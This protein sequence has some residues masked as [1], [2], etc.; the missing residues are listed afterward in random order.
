MYNKVSKDLNF[1]D[2]EKKVL[3]FW[4]NNDVYKKSIAPEVLLFLK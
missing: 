2:R 1:V 3:E 4:K